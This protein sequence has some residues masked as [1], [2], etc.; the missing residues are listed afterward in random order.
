M[1]KNNTSN[2]KLVSLFFEA[3]SLRRVLR[4][5]QQTLLT[6]DP[7]DNISSHSYRVA[8]IG[9]FLA[10]MEKADPSKVVMM[11]LFHDFAEIRSGDQNWVHKKYVKVFDDEIINDQFS[12]KPFGEEILS[13]LGQYNERKLPEASVAKDA[14]L[15]DQMLLLREYEMSG[16]KEAPVWLMSKEGIKRLVTKSAK[17]LAKEIYVQNPHSWWNKIWTSERR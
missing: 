3:G 16:N 6:T 5:H 8:L 12:D 9:W 4:S 11:C 2:Q 10:K 14:D 7:T 17:I 15:L 13:I 1:S